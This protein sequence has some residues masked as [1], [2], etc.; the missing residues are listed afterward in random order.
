MRQN[1]VASE[2]IFVDYSGK[3]IPIADPKTGEIHEAEIFVGRVRLH[4]RRGDL[5]PVTA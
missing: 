1:H 2:K 5:D 4:L 3:K